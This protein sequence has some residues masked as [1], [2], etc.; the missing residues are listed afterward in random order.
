VAGAGDG[1]ARALIGLAN[2]TI[3]AFEDVRA[4]LKH[5]G[6]LLHHH[7]SDVKS[8]VAHCLTKEARCAECASPV[9]LGRSVDFAALLYCF[10][11]IDLLAALYA[12]AAARGATQKNMATYMREV[13]R[14]TDEQV[15]LL[16]G[17]FRHKLVHLARP[18]AV[19]HHRGRC[20]TWEYAHGPHRNHLKV[21]PKRTPAH[22]W[23]GYPGTRWAADHTFCVSIPMLA[24]EIPAGAVEG[25]DSFL[26][27]LERDPDRQERF[28]RAYAQ[29][30]DT[31]RLGDGGA[32]R[33]VTERDRPGPAGGVEHE[34]DQVDGAGTSR[35]RRLR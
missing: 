1:R 3:G 31:D 28:G 16:L 9:N 10:V 15:D 6:I 35:R 25:T 7:A 29:L 12:G 22:H 23:F 27:R 20:I 19:V 18:Q 11:T 5:G 4:L 14:Y 2:V 32:R 34:R 21:Y 24:N 26:G 8:A 30:R 13:M 17:Q 33:R